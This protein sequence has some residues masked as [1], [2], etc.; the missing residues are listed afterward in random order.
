MSAS[1]YALTEYLFQALC[2]VPYGRVVPAAAKPPRKSADES[3]QILVTTCIDL[4]LEH[5]VEEVTNRRLEEVTGLNRSY[6]TRLFGTRDGL[7]LEVARELE[8][9]LASRLS[10]DPSQIDVAQIIS[11]PEAQ[12]RAQLS[13]WLMGRGHDGFDLFSGNRSMAEEVAQRIELMLGSSPR[14]ARALALHMQMT[15][16]FIALFS[17]P[18]QLDEQTVRDVLDVAQLQ[19]LH[20]GP[21]V[22][23]LGW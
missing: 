16:G 3:R 6:V 1:Q 10:P 23:Q 20:S 8:H 4:L 2:S 19:L 17:G 18:M 14:A 21:L 13:M 22:E 12:L 9:R 11:D 7:L 15:A 5:P